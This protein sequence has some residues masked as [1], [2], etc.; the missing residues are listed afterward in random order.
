MALRVPLLFAAGFLLGACLLSGGLQAADTER[1]ARK[2]TMHLTS[3]PI[4][5]DDVKSVRLIESIGV[6]DRSSSRD[7]GIDAWV[8][9]KSCRGFVIINMSNACFIRQS[10][11]RGEC[12]VEGLPSY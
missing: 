12:R 3:L 5:A 4:A 11:T 7:T 1:C 10:Y 6:S 8:Q 2:A 9:L